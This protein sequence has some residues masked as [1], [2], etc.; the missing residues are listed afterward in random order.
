MPSIIGQK[1]II[2]RLKTYTL[3]T[4]PKTILFLGQHG[5]GKS[6]IA[7]HFAEQLQI[8]PVYIDL[9]DTGG[10]VD[11]LRDDLS[12]FF[13]SPI[14]KLYLIDLTGA[15]IQAQT[16]LLKYI[17][18]PSSNMYFVLMAESEINI[19]PTILNRCIK[20]IFETYTVEQLKKLDWAIS[21]LDLDKNLVYSICKT[22]GQLL[23]LNDVKNIKDLHSLCEN[24]VTKAY[25]APYENIIKISTKI[26]YSS[27]YDKFDFD[28]FFKILTYTTFEEFKQNN[29]EFSF[30]LYNYIIQQQSKCAV[31]TKP[32]LKEHFML[33]FLDSLWRLAH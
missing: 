21:D 26:N 27:D 23:E 16:I 1:K 6:L 32:V 18:E 14:E 19:L 11:S 2:D 20:F 8:D 15:S 24:I 33:N 9:N 25:L 17:E 13:K 31:I 4:A 28:L 3:K 22:P 12:N 30:K 10:T 29:T 7:N 5:C